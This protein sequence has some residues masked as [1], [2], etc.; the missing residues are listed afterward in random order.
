M[1]ELRE[2]VAERRKSRD[3]ASPAP[4][5]RK[6]SPLGMGASTL[7]VLSLVTVLSLIPSW[8][9]ETAPA[10]VPAFFTSGCR[11]SDP[12]W[13]RGTDFA[14]SVRGRKYNPRR[15]RPSPKMHFR[16]IGG[17]ALV[18]GANGDDTPFP[19][20]LRPTQV[21]RFLWA[22]AT[23]GPAY[24]VGPVPSNGKVLACQLRSF[25]LRYRVASV[26]STTAE[27]EPGPI[28]A[29]YTQAMGPPSYTGGGVTAWFG[30][31]GDVE[32]PTRSCTS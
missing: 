13:E 20:V 10:D 7:G 21:Q 28:D 19:Q 12:L 3:P 32:A 31:L 26:I 24:P 17:Y 14:L 1:T 18:S 25:L 11:Q 16:I 30:V 9:L 27:A 8:P 15:G 5:Q 2:P 4:S 6:D 23:G 22:K 29:L